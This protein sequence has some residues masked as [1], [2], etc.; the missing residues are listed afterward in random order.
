M[1]ISNYKPKY[2]F[3]NLETGHIFDSSN[4]LKY[5]TEFYHK[6]PRRKNTTLIIVDNVTGELIKIKPP[7]HN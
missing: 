3:K 6:V 4:D 7:K 2:T 5:L 1:F